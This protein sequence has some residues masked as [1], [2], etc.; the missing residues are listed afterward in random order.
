M[1]QRVLDKL[2]TR[3][4]KQKHDVDA[5]LTAGQVDVLTAELAA[6]GIT[7]RS[8]LEL[9][10]LRREDLAREPYSTVR[11]ESTAGPE[12][13]RVRGGLTAE[14]LPEA[15]E[16]L[17]EA[18]KPPLL[19][20]AG[21][22]LEQAAAGTVDAAEVVKLTHER[23]AQECAINTKAYRHYKRG[24]LITALTQR[25]AWG[26][27]L[28][29]HTKNLDLR[30][31]RLEAELDS[32]RAGVADPQP[33]VLEAVKRAREALAPLAWPLGMRGAPGSSSACACRYDLI[34][35]LATI[36]SDSIIPLAHPF[37]MVLSDQVRNCGYK[38]TNSWRWSELTKNLWAGAWVCGASAVSLVGH[39]VSR[40]GVD[41]RDTKAYLAAP[42]SNMPLPSNTTLR[43]H[44]RDVSKNLLGVPKVPEEGSNTSRCRS[45][46]GLLSY[47]VHTAAK[48]AGG[49]AVSLAPWF[50]QQQ[51][52]A[53]PAAAAAGRQPARALGSRFTAAAEE[54]A[55]TALAPPAAPEVLP[56]TAVLVPAAAAAASPFGG[57]Q[58]P[59]QAAGAEPQPA[60]AEAVPAVS[61]AATSASPLSA[62]LPQ[63]HLSAVDMKELPQL[64]PAAEL[65][66]DAADARLAD[67][68]AAL[69]G[70]GLAPPAPPDLAGLAESLAAGISSLLA[71]Y[72]APSATGS[73]PQAPA[74]G[75]ALGM[76]SAGALQHVQP[77]I[78]VLA[79]VGYGQR[80]AAEAMAT[81]LL[82]RHHS[83]GRRRCTWISWCAPGRRRTV[84]PHIWRSSWA[85]W[86]LTCWRPWKQRC[87]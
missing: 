30:L 63:R 51:H 76:L 36:I 85:H 11:T 9:G 53:E 24:E 57:G 64:F 86:R 18:A 8:G 68:V 14:E 40:P 52:A 60:A 1:L 35:N 19:S 69:K 3:T 50:R 23:L 12:P 82:R 74:L 6:Q 47:G 56:R 5:A 43:D 84:L 67:M 58:A 62:L 20:P 79:W 37:L 21:K 7:T 2:R 27:A 72:A 70:L 10:Q 26:R 87:R 13:K 29:R 34:S 83:I 46:V 32:Y 33:E 16:L 4:Q 49:V 78:V 17:A 31:L 48:L 39:T 55:A 38:T 44:A 75:S 54:P 42:L 73:L 66:G 22:R 15:R 65:A 61:P 80:P 25:T 71:P 77:A 81:A 41:P 59:A 45:R 28:E